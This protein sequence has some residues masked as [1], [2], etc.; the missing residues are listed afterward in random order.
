MTITLPESRDRAGSIG[1]NRTFRRLLRA[2]SVSMLGSHV[3]SIAY[4][5]LILHL[6]GSPFTAGCAVFATTAPSIWHTY[7]QVPSSTDGVHGGA[8]GGSCC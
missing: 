5:L 6:T 8:R 2:S 3:T 4:P 1:E 7:P